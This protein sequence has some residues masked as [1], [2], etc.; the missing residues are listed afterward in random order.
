[1]VGDPCKSLI[2]LLLNNNVQK[3]NPTIADIKNCFFSKMAANSNPKFFHSN[4]SYAKRSSTTRYM[5]NDKNIEWNR[6]IENCFKSYKKEIWKNH[7]R[8][9]NLNSNHVNSFLTSDLASLF[10]ITRER[11]KDTK[12]YKEI[13][14]TQLTEVRI[15]TIIVCKKQPIIIFC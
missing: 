8:N 13:S 2:I 9:V 1:M 5:A 4:R 14:L 15:K 10:K 6:K 7:T 12:E 11:L 3:E